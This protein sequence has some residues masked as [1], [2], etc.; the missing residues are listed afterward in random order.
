MSAAPARLAGLAHRK[1]RLAPGFDADIV[2]W[3]PEAT[4]T[5]NEGALFHRHRLTPYL[6][7]A[8]HGRV[9]ATFVAGWAAYI[10][11]DVSAEP[12]GR[13]CMRHER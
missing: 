2:I 5:V 10:D 11:G 7:A 3:D 6:G 4:F 13:I 9:L 8:L 12:V 1:G